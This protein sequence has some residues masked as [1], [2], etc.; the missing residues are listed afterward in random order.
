MDGA[1]LKK[2]DFLGASLN[3]RVN[4]QYSTLTLSLLSKDLQEGLSIFFDLLQP[5]WNGS[6]TSPRAVS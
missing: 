2:A 1:A 3:F 6:L 4:E 5:G